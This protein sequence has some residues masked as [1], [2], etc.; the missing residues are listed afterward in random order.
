MTTPTTISPASEQQITA[1]L[2]LFIAPTQVT[3]LRCLPRDRRQGIIAGLFDG[4][5]LPQ[6][7]REAVYY[8]HKDYAVYFTPNPLNPEVMDVH[9]GRKN[10]A[11]AGKHK[12]KLAH[13][14]DVLCRRWLMIDV[15]PVRAAGH[16][17]ES[18]TDVEKAEAWKVAELVRYELVG[19]DET[20]LPD[21]W[22]EPI[23]VDSGNGYHLYFAMPTDGSE[24]V[25][26][27]VNDLLQ[28]LAFLYDT[29]TA[30][31]DTTVSNPARIMRVPGT[32]SNKGVSTSDRP[33][34]VSGVMS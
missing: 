11:V 6:M 26:S 25:E 15:D 34:R 21:G 8:N 4:E 20:V 7:A 28:G 30:M 5:H 3:E 24:L 18:S 14:A 17:K 12:D 10:R 23:I 16:D 1:W 22:K 27:R 2:S 19:N 31:I 13:D 29:A 32:V 9:P 33:H